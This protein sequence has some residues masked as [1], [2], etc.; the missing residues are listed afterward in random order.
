[1]LAAEGRGRHVPM[2]G[3]KQIV[4][5]ATLAQMWTPQLT[6]E[7]TGFGLGFMVGKFRKH[8]AISHNGAVYGHSTSLVF[9]PES[10]IGVVLLC[11]ED[12]VN[13][14]V[15]RLSNLGG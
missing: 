2:A 7:E 12:I 9:L 10:K 1:M 15:G 8:K 5:P 11:N 6:K 13:G 14:N 4:S 3:D